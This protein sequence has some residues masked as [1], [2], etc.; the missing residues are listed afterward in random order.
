MENIKFPIVIKKR[1]AVMLGVSV[2]EIGVGVTFGITGGGIKS[3]PLW[4]FVF[5]GIISALTVLVEYSLDISLNENRVEF[6]KNKDLIKAIKYGSINS[7]YISKGNETKTK[8]KDFFTIGF[9]SSDN[10]K[11]KDEKYLINP[12]HYSSKDLDTIK[13]IIVSKN[14]SVKVSDD[15]KKFVR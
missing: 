12:M 4:V 14:Y 11:F 1:N 10:K 8:K 7:I 13:N 15:I 5:T 6:Y 9:N 2:L 3:I